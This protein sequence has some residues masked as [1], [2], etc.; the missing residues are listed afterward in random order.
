MKQYVDVETLLPARL[1]VTVNIPQIGQDVEQ[2][3]EPSDFRDVGGMKV[4][5]TL[6]LTSSVQSFTVN[7]AKVEANVALDEKMFSKP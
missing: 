5:H 3:V 2:V 6:R 7:I 4:P 1:A